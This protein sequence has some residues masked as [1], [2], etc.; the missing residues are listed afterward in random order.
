MT[1]R[2][3]N[4]GFGWKVLGAVYHQLG[5]NQ[6]AIRPMKK[7]V[8]L[9]PNDAAVHSNLGIVL[10]A[11]GWH[12]DALVSHRR[13][14]KIQPNYTMALSNLGNTLHE[15]GRLRE[16]EASYRRA[17]KIKP[18]Y[19]EAHGNLGITLQGLGRLDEAEASYRRALEINPVFVEAHSNM[20]KTLQDMGR[21]DEAEATYRRALEI[22]PDYAEA[23][24]NLG[25]TLQEL[26]RTDE[27]EASYLQALKIN[28]QYAEAHG[29][30]GLTLQSLDRLAEAEARYRR[31]LELKPDYA[32]GLNNLALLLQDSGRLEE[33]AACFRRALEIR[34]DYA[35]ALLSMGHLLCNLDDF[36]QAAEA[37]QK[38]AEVDPARRGLEATVNLA[39][40]N[41]LNSN[42]EQCRSNLLASQPL[43]AKNDS[44]YIN[45][46]IYWLY[47]DK[48]LSCQP[49]SAGGDHAESMG[50]L[51]VVGDSHSLATHG[52]VIR[53]DDQNKRCAAEWI[54]G[55]KQWHLGNSQPNKYKYKF[56][57]VMARLPREST[58][59]LS[60]GEIDCR[61][62]EGILTVWK[63][64][65]E[66][67]LDEIVRSTVDDYLAYVGS[68][69]ARYGHK[70]I[71]GGVP[72]SNISPDM[73]GPDS[74]GQ[75]VQL[76]RIFNAALKEQALAAGMSFL[77]VYSLTDGGDGIANSAW[78]IDE[79]H[80]KPDAVVAAFDR[81]CIRP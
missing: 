73:L 27:A 19:A 69:G 24:S 32:E 36:T 47:L 53:Y 51:Y 28:P 80:L 35:D 68:A 13:A 7:A 20:G 26:G 37:Y 25:I 5:R 22:K 61:P 10:S 38:V 79:I 48:L 42:F 31:A 16:A 1:E 66:K 15:M 23:H 40:L 54:A 67:S 12:D 44:K 76:I 4:H 72:C 9:L 8:A 11:L 21:L 65:P 57:R 62:D 2:F 71:V 49:R 70:L 46:R 64:H 59:L 18:D 52:M 33:A 14:L 45:H 17:L 81:Y 6:E 30:L 50:A 75:L 29:N 55:C 41:F 3:P 78:H 63:K 74:A 39:I 43:L 77:D 56:E 60:I 34:P 58:V